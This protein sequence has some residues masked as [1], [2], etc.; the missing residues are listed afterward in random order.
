M[1][2]ETQ[3]WMATKPVPTETPGYQRQSHSAVGNC[4]TLRVMVRRSTEIATKRARVR[5]K[6]THSSTRAKSMLVAW[7]VVRA[8]VEMGPMVVLRTAGWLATWRP[9]TILPRTYHRSHHGSRRPRRSRSSRRT[10]VTV[11]GVTAS[12]PANITESRVRCRLLPVAQ[13]A[14]GGPS[15]KGREGRRQKERR[16]VDRRWWRWQ[17]PNLRWLHQHHQC[18]MA[19]R[20]RVMMNFKPRRNPRVAGR[21]C[22]TVTP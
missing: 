1:R 17:R 20:L 22:S 4:G 11:L 15:C 7:L 10:L 18:T 9:S 3:A 21:F 6:S 2:G 13:R 14:G 19:K 8:I 12:G 5:R 16:R